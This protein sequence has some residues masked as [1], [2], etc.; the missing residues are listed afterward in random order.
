MCGSW[1]LGGWGVAV[2]VGQDNV[3]AL[4]LLAKRPDPGRCRMAIPT[5]R[6]LTVG[7]VH[8]VSFG[9]YR[10]LFP[11]LLVIA[12]VSQVIPVLLTVYMEAA[13]GPEVHLAMAVATYC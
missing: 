10:S 3:R 11:P 4:R 8:D 5:L 9:L 6:P 1:G 2:P 7:E 12:S 13:G